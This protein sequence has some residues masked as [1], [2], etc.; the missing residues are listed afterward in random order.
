MSELIKKEVVI[1]Y[2]IDENT[3]DDIVFATN[4][5]KFTIINHATFNAI[6]VIPT[7][8]G[9]GSI[10]IWSRHMEAETK[11]TINIKVVYESQE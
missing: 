3:I 2:T 5:N 8:L 9:S 11:K 10:T 1:N 6:N 7:G 4:A